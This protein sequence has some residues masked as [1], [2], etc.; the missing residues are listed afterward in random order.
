M[1]ADL[2]KSIPGVDVIE[3]LV[4]DDGSTDGTVKTAHQNN[5]HHV[6]SLGKNKGLAQ[7]FSDG[8]DAALQEGATIIVNTDADNQYDGASIPNLIAPILDGYADME[9]GARPVSEMDHFSDVIS[10]SPG[11]SSIS[12]LPF[13][14][15]YLFRHLQTP[16]PVQ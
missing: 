3:Y 6:V 1:L 2:P 13:L 9:V 5:A 8:L 15:Y 10:Q 4:I 14:H 12:L 16:P 11:V 7:A